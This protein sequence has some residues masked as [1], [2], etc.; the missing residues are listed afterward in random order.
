MTRKAAQVAQAAKAFMACALLL[1]AAAPALASSVA[2]GPSPRRHSRDSG[3]GAPARGNQTTAAARPPEWYMS[4]YTLQSRSRLWRMW[5][6]LENQAFA[7]AALGPLTAWD[8]SGETN[9]A[10]VFQGAADFNEG[11]NAYVLFWRAR[12]FVQEATRKPAKQGLR[13]RRGRCRR[14][15]LKS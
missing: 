11:L 3:P 6:A 9:L 7:L 12:L 13:E 10:R 8:T 15:L 1:L 5:L 14:L 2:F 4:R